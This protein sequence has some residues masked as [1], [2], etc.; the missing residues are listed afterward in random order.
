MNKQQTNIRL[1]AS[2]RKKLRMIAALLDK[3]Q[4]AVVGEAI[5]TQAAAL[6]ITIQPAIPEAT[7]DD[8]DGKV[9]A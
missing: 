9:A 1:T 8:A 6:G 7:D 3:R 2:Q 4:S 5:D